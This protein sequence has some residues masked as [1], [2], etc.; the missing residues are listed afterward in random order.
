MSVLAAAASGVVYGAL[1]GVGPDHCAALASL[2]ARDHEGRMALRI[3]LRFGL[4]H[5]LALGSIAAVATSA[6]WLIPSSWESAA[7]VAGGVVLVVLG[8][9]GL[10]RANLHLLVHRHT[11]EHGRNHH[12]H[13]HLHVNH[14]GKEHQHMHLA[15]VVGGTFALSGVRALALALP[16]LLLA[17]KAWW[18]GAAFV[19][20]FGIGVTA[21]MAVVGLALR[22]VLSR[23]SGGTRWDAA[24]TIR[25]AIAAGST[26][27]GAWWIWANVP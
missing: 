19:V 14:R 18:A 15:T 12:E 26:V 27:L 6:G 3:S 24:R 25:V 16:P 23:P 2:V 10:R 17:G 4:S 8:V 20:C 13:W 9:L 7:E 22:A 11:H 21:S 1:H 5:A